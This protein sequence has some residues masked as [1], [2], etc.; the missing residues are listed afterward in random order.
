[1]HEDDERIRV[2]PFDAVEIELAGWWWTDD[3][4]R[5][6]TGIDTKEIDTKQT[7]NQPTP[8]RWNVRTIGSCSECVALI[9]MARSSSSS[10]VRG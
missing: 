1:M 2:A 8:S 6:I 3:D 7:K 5:F 10:A 4:P 9:S